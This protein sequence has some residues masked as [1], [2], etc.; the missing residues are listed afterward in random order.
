MKISSNKLM[1]KEAWFWL[2]I[3]TGLALVLRLWLMRFLT[4]LTFDEIVSYSVATKPLGQI[5][6][7]VRWEM[8][9]PLHYYYLHFWLQ[10]FGQSEVSA[11]LSSVFLSV[12]GT[13][14][15]YFLGKEV[16]KTESAGLFAAALYA[17][18]PLFCFFG[19]WARMY[20]MLFLMAT[21]SFLFFLKLIKVRG[22]KTIIFGALYTFFT[23]AAL[24]THLTAGLVIAVEAAYLAFLFFTRQNTIKEMLKKFFIPALIIFLTYGVWFW[25]FLNQRLKA[26]DG[27]AWYFNAQ[28]KA[29]FLTVIFYDSIR[30]L[31]LFDPYLFE[32][33]ASSLLA[34]LLFSV[35]S[36]VSPDDKNKIKTRRRFSNGAFFSLLIFLLSLIGLFAAKLLILRYA[37]IPA[38]GLFLLLGYGFSL[39]GRFLQTAAV[40]IFLILTIMSFCAF[41]GPAVNIEDWKGVADFISQNER[42][43]DKIIAS[44]DFALL[45]LNFYY[46]GALPV[47]APL[48]EKYR[49]DD[50]LLTAIKTNMYPTTDKNNIGQL[51]N[52]LGSSSRIFLIISDGAG[53]FPGVSRLAED[54]LTTKGFAKVPRCPGA[55]GC[56]A[57]VWLAERT[58]SR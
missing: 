57:Y 11:H 42:P 7:Y 45:P 26:L 19:I 47:A 54:W 15:L 32:L 35:F 34:I 5:W 12:L 25:Y 16:F 58:S 44:L 14:A 56:P 33:L 24:F 55:N 27:S 20:S 2:V 23:L 6:S 53:S 52:F 1:L 50:L 21:L 4:S 9:P 30:Y 18:S 40:V 38:I 22:R 43:G 29:S 13:A 49:G 8:H 48:D 28:G 3:I 51:E 17:F 39:A 46:H 41:A 36:A 31:T 37:I 10:F